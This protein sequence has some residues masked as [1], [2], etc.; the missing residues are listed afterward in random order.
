MGELLRY[1]WRTRDCVM[2]VLPSQVDNA[3]Y[4]VVL[5]CNGIV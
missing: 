5:D 3:G 4:D 2:E 1:L